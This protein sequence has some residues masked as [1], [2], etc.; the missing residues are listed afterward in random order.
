VGTSAVGLAT[1][2]LATLA[3]FRLVATVAVLATNSLVA[4]VAVLAT[5]SLVTTIAIAVFAA[6]HSV[7]S[8]FII[9]SNFHFIFRSEIFYFSGRRFY[10]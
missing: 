5:S 6:S 10:D 3:T 1:V 8:W 7:S 9:S 2:G 4:T